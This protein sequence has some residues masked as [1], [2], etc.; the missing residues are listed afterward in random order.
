M[1]TK[2][3]K[4]HF[5]K[6]FT[7]VELIIVIAVIA[8]I[9][10]FA[11]PNFTN[12]LGD[13]QVTQV[14]NDTANITNMVTA[15]IQEVGAVPVANIS[16]TEGNVLTQG[17]STST[18][19]DLASKNADKYYIL[20]MDLLTK[21]Q[22][23]IENPS[24]EVPA[25]VSMMPSTSAIVDVQTSADGSGTAGNVQTAKS[26]KNT[27][28]VYVI[29]SELRVFAAYNKGIKPKKTGD[30]AGIAT[31]SY[32]ILN[33]ADDHI[34]GSATENHKNF[35]VPF[36]TVTNANVLAGLDADDSNYKA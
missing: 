3:I 4:R 14:K 22:A 10:I 20:D 19:K 18:F 6:A 31:Q 5:K 12:V 29:D 16:G 25:K 1:N 28:V 33:P 26:I 8:I 7:L 35:K 11:L 21:K 15:Y 27:S 17:I 2:K 30:L 32:D 23:N 34:S 9:A 24:N 36:K 13:T